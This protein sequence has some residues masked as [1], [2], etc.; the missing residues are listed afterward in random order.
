M[1]E[2]HPRAR[3]AL[4]TGGSRG[5]GAAISK[6]LAS[7]GNRVG[8]NYK[9]NADDADAVVAAIRSAGGEAVS[10]PGDVCDPASV[11]QL[12]AAV[13][14]KLGPI[15]ILVH[16]ALIPYVGKS[17]EEIS[18]EELGGKN[19]LELQAAFHLTKAVTPGMRERQFGRIVYLSTG[20]VRRPRKGMVALGTSKAGL[21]AFARF[22]AQEYGPDGIT[23]NVVAP[24]PVDG[25]KYVAIMGPFGEQ[26][27]RLIKE[28]P[29]RRFALPE[30]VA[31]VIAF[32]VGEDGAY[33]TGSFMAV[34][35]GYTMD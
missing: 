4:V 24:G 19:N 31:R 10:V 13:E 27:E 20:L 12:V 30:D 7:R 17:F 35:G 14:Q 29:L 23:V 28:T 9:S 1:S 34:N 6:L 5:I 21:S 15:D 26:R 16:N 33:V 18:W 11:R 8:V 3:V 2:S 32:F 25:T 22:V